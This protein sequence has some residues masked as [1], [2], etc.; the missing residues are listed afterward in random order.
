MKTEMSA[1]LKLEEGESKGS[2]M[3]PLHSG[4]TL[5]S[6]LEPLEWMLL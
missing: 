3:G 6:A 4:K 2:E 1:R 5:H